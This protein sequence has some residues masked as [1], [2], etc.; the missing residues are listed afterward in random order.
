MNIEKLKELGHSLIEEYM[1][2]L[3]RHRTDSKRERTYE[4]L[5][6]AMKGRNPHFG[7]MRNKNEV[8]LAIGTLKKMIVRKQ[9]ERLRTKTS[10]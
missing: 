10:H 9:Y 8:M 3:P 5:R 4:E 7:Q 6:K 2:F 1:S